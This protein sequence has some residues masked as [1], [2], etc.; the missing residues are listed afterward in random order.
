M[1]E[2][3]AKCQSN[4]YSPPPKTNNHV[5]RTQVYKGIFGSL[6]EKSFHFNFNQLR[7]KKTKDSQ[8][9]FLVITA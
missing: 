6:G 7:K 3:S 2:N 5:V 8:G 9:I 1:M 4:N